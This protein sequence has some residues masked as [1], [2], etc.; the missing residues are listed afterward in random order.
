MSCKELTMAQAVNV[1]LT[2]S[3]E[4]DESV[5]C[6]GLGVDD[7]LRIFGTTANL[8]EN[9][10]QRVFDMPTCEN[11]MTGVGIG[12]ALNGLKPVMVH[13]RLDF[14]L[15]AMDQL[16]NAAAKWHY[17][18]NGQSNVPIVI[19]LMI[20]R[21]WGQGPTHSQ[22][23]H[24]WFAHIPGL[25]VVMPTNPND[26]YHML[27]QAIQD[28]NPVIFIEHRWLHGQVGLIE[29]GSHSSI[30]KAKLL[31]KGDDITIIA[32][33]YLTVEAIRA[34]EALSKNSVNVELIDLMTV[35]PIDWETIYESVEKTGRLLVLDT[36]AETGSVAGE[37]VAKVSEKC[38]AHLKAA[39][40]RLAMPD[41]PEPT[42]YGLTKQFYF[43]AK[44]IAEK[45]HGMLLENVDSSLYR[46]LDT[47][48]HHDIPGSH[49]KG[50]F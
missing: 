30:G 35:K 40:S 28:P 49:F 38:F 20:G 44:E 41:I 9:F 19:R 22:N 42:S 18:F 29:K 45:V 4:M 15:L 12:A 1:A 6:Y 23:L 7:P 17:M 5:I 16:V 32:M 26:A 21:G 47:E 39:P 10:P 11:A 43:G 34:S 27:K 2:E 46:E 25:K 3:M 33:S 13:Q 31:K 8:S 50:P 14:F 36:G 48:G 37:I 24:A